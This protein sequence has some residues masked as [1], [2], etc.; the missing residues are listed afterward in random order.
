MSKSLSKLIAALDESTILR[1]TG[2]VEV[3]APVVESDADV[4]PGGAFVARR[5]MKADGHDFIPRAL[6]RGAAAVIGDRD[7]KDLPVPY[8]QVQHAQEATGFLA[9]AYHD[10]PSCKMVVIG[11]TGTNGK[12]TTVTLIHSILKVATHNKAGMISTVAADLGSQVADTGF[13]VTTPGAP[14]IQAYLAQMVNSGLTHCV[15]EMTS[16]GL[17]QGRLNGVDIDVAVMTNVTHEHLNDHGSFENYRAAKIRMF[18]MLSHSLSKGDQP[19]IAVINADDPSADYFAALPADQYILY[20]LGSSARLRAENIDYGPHAT[21]IAVNSQV[22]STPLTGEFNVANVLAAVACAQGLGLDAATIQAGLDQVPGIP[23]R[24]ERIDEG[25]DFVAMVDFA[26]TPDALEKALQAG[27]QILEPGKRLIAVFGSAG[28]RDREKR[29]LMSEISAQLADITIVTAE[30]PRTESLD[31]ILAVMAAA[32]ESQGG[33]EGETFL[34]VADRG[35]AIFRACQMA[36]S[37]IWSWPVARG[38]SRVCASVRLSIP[39]MIARPCGRLY[40]AQ[41]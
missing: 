16:H 28:L 3:R 8:V 6:E 20:G 21:R 22:F 13:H 5:G 40:A 32:C 11:V 41:P 12:T 39:G 23:G 37:G 18:E 27:R 9:A 1:I 35:E 10:F 25:Q 4:E 15:L 19:K 36:Q 31:E 26:H 33:V 30:D 14:Q 24:L 2:D 17:A 7:L 34:R 29:R 38:M